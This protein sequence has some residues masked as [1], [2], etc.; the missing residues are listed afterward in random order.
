M[1]PIVKK[2]VECTPEEVDKICS[3]NLWD[4]Q[5]IMSF[6][7]KKCAN[8]EYPLSALEEHFSSIYAGG[9]ICDA[10]HTMESSVGARAWFRI[11]HTQFLDEQKAKK[12]MM[13]RNNYL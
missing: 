1:L 10:C 4:L 3:N 2:L 7:K 8:C 9:E 12:R 6:C 13:D 11:C 5:R